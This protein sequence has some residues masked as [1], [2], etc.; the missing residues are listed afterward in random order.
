MVEMPLFSSYLFV[1][2]TRAALYDLTRVNGVARIVY[3][4]GQ[5]AVVRPQEIKAIRQ[6]L[7]Y[8][9]GKACQLELDDEVRVAVGPMKDTGGKVIKI[10]KKYVVLLLDKLGLQVQVAMDTVIKK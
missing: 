7:A 10:G 9:N 4:E 8:A 2:T 6:F 1:H 3:F 5:P